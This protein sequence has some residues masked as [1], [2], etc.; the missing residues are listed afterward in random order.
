MYKK[1]DNKKRF[2]ECGLEVT[3]KDKTSKKL[4]SN[5]R[6]GDITSAKIYYLSPVSPFRFIFLNSFL[7]FLVGEQS[8]VPGY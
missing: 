3:L 6:V 2:K 1:K 4:I 7:I 8:E 5:T